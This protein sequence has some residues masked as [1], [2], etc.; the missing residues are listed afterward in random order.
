MPKPLLV[1]LD[2][3]PNFSMSE[4]KKISEKRGLLYSPHPKR[5][6]APGLQILRTFWGLSC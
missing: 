3:F 1:P 4:V 2:C 5:D 6:S